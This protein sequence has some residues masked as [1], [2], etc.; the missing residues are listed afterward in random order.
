MIV[1]VN[2]KQ[3][4]LGLVNP[5][6]VAHVDIAPGIRLT[7]QLDPRVEGGDFV[8][9]QILQGMMRLSARVADIERVIASIPGCTALDAL[10]PG[11]DPTRQALA[12][13]HATLAAV[14]AAAQGAKG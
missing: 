8:I 7:L 6:A 1:D 9:W 14:N 5:G 10:A 2:E 4:G 12:R 13:I 11:D 3:A